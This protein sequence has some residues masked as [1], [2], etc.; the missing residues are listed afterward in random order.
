[1]SDT[2]PAPK[3]ES[4]S[5]DFTPQRRHARV[6]FEVEVNVESDHNFYTGFTQNISEGG[7]F[8]ATS[9]LL[10]LGSK[11]HFSFRLSGGGEA[12]GIYGI[13]RWVREH[14]PMTED[15]PA[16]MGVQFV[17]L[18]PAVAEQVNQFIRRQR[19][20]IFYDD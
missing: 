9:R 14:G 12:V 1:M 11:I 3:P 7:L 5:R 10:P 15:A 16:G 13:V 17:D 4:L 8:I 20:T 19:D 6:P 18:A 2:N